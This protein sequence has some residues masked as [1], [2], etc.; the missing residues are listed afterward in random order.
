MI[1]PIAVEDIAWAM[2]LAHQRYKKIFDPGHALTV[3]TMAMRLPTALAWRTDHGFLIANIVASVWHPQRRALHI[4]AVC[5]EEGHHWE[6]VEL[7]RAS[8]RWAREQGWQ[9]WWLTSESEHKVDALARRIG[10]RAYPH[11]VIELAEDK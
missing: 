10:G 3:L 11:Y 8:V 4:L 6:A 7:L 5:V 2:S 1:R 9:K